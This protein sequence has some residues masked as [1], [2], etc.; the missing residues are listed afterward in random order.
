LFAAAILASSEPKLARKLAAFRRK[1]A[2][3]VRA[4]KLPPIGARSLK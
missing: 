3:T 1:Q 4:M 2:A